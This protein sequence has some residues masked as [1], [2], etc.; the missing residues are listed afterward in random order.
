M[1]RFFLSFRSMKNYFAIKGI[2]KVSERYLTVK[3]FQQSRS[4]DRS[5]PDCYG[6]GYLRISVE[7]NCNSPGIQGLT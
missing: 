3:D 6:R 5:L 4:T 1:I 7:V 2:D